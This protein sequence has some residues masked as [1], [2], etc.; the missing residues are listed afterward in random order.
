MIAS[1]GEQDT[2]LREG[3]SMVLSAGDFLDLFLLLTDFGLFPSRLGLV[4]FLFLCT[5]TITISLVVSRS[6][7][8]LELDPFRE[9]SFVVLGTVAEL[10]L[11]VAAPGIHL[12]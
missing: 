1:P 11:F 12:K 6:C 3:K 8:T 9:N 5:I 2:V 7:G 4:F 10:G